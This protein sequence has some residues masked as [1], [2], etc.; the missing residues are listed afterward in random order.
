MTAAAPPCSLLPLPRPRRR[1]QLRQRP[2]PRPRPRQ[3]QGTPA[4]R[5]GLTAA[6]HPVAP[7]RLPQPQ[8]APTRRSPAYPARLLAP[9][10]RGRRWPRQ[11]Q[12]LPRRPWRPP[13]PQPQGLRLPHLLMLL[14]LL[15]L[16]N[17]GVLRPLPPS[18]PPSP[19]PPPPPPQLPPL[20]APSGLG[21]GTRLP[22]PQPLPRPTQP[23]RAM[24]RARP[25]LGAAP[26]RHA[27]GSHQARA[28]PAPRAALRLTRGTREMERWPGRRPPRAHAPPW[29]RGCRSAAAAGRGRWWLPCLGA[30]SRGACRP[31][32]SW[33][34]LRAAWGL[35][36]ARPG[37]LASQQYAP[38]CQYPYFLTQ[39]ARCSG[40]APQWGTRGQ[41]AR[42]SAA[43]QSG[44]RRY[45]GTW[46]V[47]DRR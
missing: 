34:P 3:R 46:A 28:P 17:L 27:A 36:P 47:R 39:A 15:L 1:P 22:E 9:Q 33:P 7:P 19:P 29:L 45:H 14:L 40:S 16:L 42:R 26:A 4:P 24:R 10:L 18:P 8:G 23:A 20:L 11:A 43:A 21:R 2:R 5:P 37:P 13:W 38:G 35:L 6:S 32:A 25:A 44:R 41:A 12:V 30:W 31:W